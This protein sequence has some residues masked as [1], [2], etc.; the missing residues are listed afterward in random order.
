MTEGDRMQWSIDFV[1]DTKSTDII[2]SL[3]ASDGVGATVVTSCIL[4]ASN[5]A[6]YSHHSDNNYIRDSKFHVCND[7]QC[8]E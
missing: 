6:W 4:Y 2:E 1:A 3:L 8:I 7:H 5:D